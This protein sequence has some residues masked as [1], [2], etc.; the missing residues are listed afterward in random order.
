MLAVL[1]MHHHGDAGTA[2]RRA[3]VEQR[4]DLVG[5]HDVRSQLVEQR[6][7]PAERPKADPGRLLDA[8]QPYSLGLELR[9]QHAGALQ[10][11]HDHA[12]PEPPALAH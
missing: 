9:R 11:D 3:G 6:S 2:R 1:G 12:L 5:V 8:S 7:Q 10:A 4:P